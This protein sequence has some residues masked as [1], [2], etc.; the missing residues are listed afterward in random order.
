MDIITY[1]VL[2]EWSN[3]FEWHDV[4]GSVKYVLQCEYISSLCASDTSKSR[5]PT[6]V[7]DLGFPK[8]GF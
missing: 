1:Y 8:G 3:T 2:S 7:A 6:A 5:I 4:R